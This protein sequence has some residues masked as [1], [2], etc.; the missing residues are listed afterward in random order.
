M[1]ELKLTG[2]IVP[3]ARPRVSFGRAYLP[4][5]YRNWKDSAIAELMTQYQ[6]EPLK[7]VESVAI[8]L[9]GK[10]SRRGDA[11][12]IAGALLDAMVQGGLL[13]N[14]NLTVVPKLSITLSYDKKEPPRC[15]IA[16]FTTLA[17]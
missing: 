3:K 13:V 16:I 10:H 9:T 14:D 8:E 6:G 1:I 15:S 5:N 7:A 11:D 2:D 4:Q 12:N 17:G